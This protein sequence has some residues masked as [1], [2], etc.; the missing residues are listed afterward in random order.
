MAP[1]IAESIGE[2]GAIVVEGS[3][4]DGK[5]GT[6]HGFQSMLAVFVPKVVATISTR[7]HKRAMNWVEFYHIH[8]I[9]VCPISLTFEGEVFALQM[10]PGLI[11]SGSGFGE[12]A[13]PEAHTSMQLEKY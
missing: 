2:D 1:I 6:G 8:C 10:H 11:H 3:A 4:G 13:I 7:R 5:I 9:D 12:S